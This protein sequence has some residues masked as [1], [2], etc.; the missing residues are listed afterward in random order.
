MH[1]GWELRLLLR[2]GLNLDMY[3]D[4]KILMSEE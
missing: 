2:D 4:S 1:K 3:N